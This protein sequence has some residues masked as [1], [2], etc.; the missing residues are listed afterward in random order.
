MFGISAVDFLIEI[1]YVRQLQ[2]LFSS[3][4]K[5]ATHTHTH[6]NIYIYIYI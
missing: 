4:I 5:Y 2:I 3:L 1:L 6:T